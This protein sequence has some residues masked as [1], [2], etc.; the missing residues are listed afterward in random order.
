MKRR[1]RR[2]RRDSQAVIISGE[3]LLQKA[4]SVARITQMSQVTQSVTSNRG[5][6]L[7][8]IGHL[9]GLFVLATACPPSYAA[10]PF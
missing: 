1:R 6:L 9:A 5:A 8:L 7:N 3:K 10:D 2:S 4:F